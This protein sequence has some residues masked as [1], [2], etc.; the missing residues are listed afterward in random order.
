MVG[1]SQRFGGKG[2]P[3]TPEQL[4]SDLE[5]ELE[6][7]P[8]KGS[9]DSPRP[10]TQRLS[11]QRGKSIEIIEEVCEE[12]DDDAAENQSGPDEATEVAEPEHDKSDDLDQ[13][14]SQSSPMPLPLDDELALGLEDDAWG[15]QAGE[16][17]VS[18]PDVAAIAEEERRISPAKP[19]DDVPVEEKPAVVFDELDQELVADTADQ[20]EMINEDANVVD[21]SKEVQQPETIDIVQQ[22]SVDE[23]LKKEKVMEVQKQ[24]VVES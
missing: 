13:Q 8:D 6:V 23:V 19:E 12:E 21:G 16:N 10:A 1:N 18:L 17:R 20:I 14:D 9:E 15:E 3:G 24:L 22:D 11:Q 2:D 7:V 4:L 5:E